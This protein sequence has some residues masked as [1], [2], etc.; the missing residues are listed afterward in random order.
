VAGFVVCWFTA[1]TLTVTFQC[2]P[3]SFAWDKNVP[4][5]RCIDFKSFIFSTAVIN[6]LTDVVIVFMPVPVIWKLQM[7]STKKIGICGIFLLGS[8]VI[9]ASI[10]RLTTLNAVD[11]WDVACKSSSSSEMKRAIY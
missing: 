8:I 7:P 10:F 6:V 1:V 3:V 5:G 9:L 4:D 2:T 11:T